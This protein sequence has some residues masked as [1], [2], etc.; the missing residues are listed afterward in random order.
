MPSSRLGG[1]FFWM[2]FVH[3]VTCQRKLDNLS[4]PLVFLPTVPQR[5]V[6]FYDVRV[7][8]NHSQRLGLLP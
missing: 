4:L 7:N 1:V 2:T 6:L 3:D 8:T 5:L